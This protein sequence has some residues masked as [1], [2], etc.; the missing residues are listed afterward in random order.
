[1]YSRLG[2]VLASRLQKKRSNAVYCF[3]ASW[4]N[5]RSPSS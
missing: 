5:P 1:M 4:M 2:N 3:A